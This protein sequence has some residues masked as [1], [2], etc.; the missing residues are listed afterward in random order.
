MGAGRVIGRSVRV[1]FEGFGI[2]LPPAIRPAMASSEAVRRLPNRV[3][4]SLALGD[5]LGHVS[6][7]DHQD[8]RFRPAFQFRR[9]HERLHGCLL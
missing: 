8:A 6:E 5:C 3:L 4:L 1:A 7:R 2:S 9:I